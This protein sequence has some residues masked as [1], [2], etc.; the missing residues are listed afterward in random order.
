MVVPALI[1]AHGFLLDAL[2]SHIQRDM[3]LP[4]RTALRSQDPQLQRIQGIS[5]ISPGHIR[6]K[7]QRILRDHSLICPHTALH[8]CQC[9]QEKRPDI[10]LLQGLQF[11]DNGP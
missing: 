1:I 8:I 3:D 5:R 9:T 10:L 6:Q 2:R 7:F 11:K 4:V